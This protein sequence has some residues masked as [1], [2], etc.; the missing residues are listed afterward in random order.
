MAAGVNPGDWAIM[1]GVPYI[2]RP[3]PLYGMRRPRSGVRGMDVAGTDA[4]IPLV[5]RGSSR[6]TP[7]FGRCTRALA[8][9]AVASE[10]LLVLKPANLSFDQAAAVPMSGSSM[11]SQA[12]RDHGNVQ[13][14]QRALVTAPQ[15]GFWDVRG[16]TRRNPSEPRSPE[17]R[18][19]DNID[20]VRSI[21]ADHLI[22]YT[23]EDFTASGERYHF[24]LDNATNHTISSISGTC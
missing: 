19:T 24:I 13:P 5:S 12:L 1:T 23:R 4:A 3:F 11:H 22:D 8:D 20:L 18:R 10:D 21:G 17:F 7:A 2:A 16:T 14:R 15:G 6:A 9:F